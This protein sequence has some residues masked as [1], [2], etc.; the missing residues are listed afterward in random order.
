[1]WSFATDP[2]VQKYLDWA[3]TFV[4]NEVEPLEAVVADDAERMDIAVEQIIPELQA[5]V[6]ANGLWAWH[7]RPEAGGMGSGHLNFALLNE[8]IG[9]STIAPLIFGCPGTDSGNMEILS[10]F[11]SDEQK[12]RYLQPLIQG[13]SRSCFASTEPSGGADPSVYQTT[14]TLDGNEWVINGEKWFA[15]GAN[16][17]AFLIVLAVTDPDADRRSR[18]SVFLVDRH[19]PGLEIVRDLS[20]PLHGPGRHSYVRFTDLRVPLDG[21]LGRRGGAR[22]VLASRMGPARTHMAMR[23]SGMLLRAYDIMCER[24]KSRTTQ[25]N[26]LGDKQ[27]VQ[28]MIAQSWLD[29]EQYRLLVLRTAWKMDQGA[30]DREI[31]ADVSALKALLSDVLH[32]VSRRAIQINGAYGLTTELPL[33]TMLMSSLV[34]GIGDGPTEIHLV[35][36]ARQ[37]LKAVPAGDEKFGSYHLLPLREKAIARYPVLA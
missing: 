1:M 13:T 20:V 12:A 24:A 21:M 28:A 8:V 14:A 11:G 5:V 31:S 7:L 37:L 26:L 36:L 33:M 30:D 18:M 16:K 23:V 9:R 32:R 6:K 2:E 29:I 34:R 25:G 4:T 22:D 19:T 3:D 17:A 35:R 10:H 27:L 15:S